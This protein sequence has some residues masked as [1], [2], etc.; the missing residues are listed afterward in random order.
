M[1]AARIDAVAEA[2]CKRHYR[3]PTQEHQLS[4]KLAQAIETELAGVKIGPFTIGVAVQDFPDK[5]KRSWEK[6]TGADLYISTVRK[7]GDN[8][9]SKGMLVQSKWD[10][11]FF[12]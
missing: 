10:K 2:V 12:P 4:A 7:D 11:T 6:P 9:F 3:A 1:I 5:G 8:T